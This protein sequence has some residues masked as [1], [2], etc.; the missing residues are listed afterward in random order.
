MEL[1]K[2]LRTC[3]IAH[4][5]HLADFGFKKITVNELIHNGYLDEIISEAGRFIILSEELRKFYATMKPDQLRLKHDAALTYIYLSKGPNEKATWVTDNGDRTDG[6]NGRPDATYYDKE[7]L[8]CVEITTPNYTTEQIMAKINYAN[9]INAK[10]EVY[11][12]W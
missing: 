6:F 8:V 2:T 7:T 12:I 10:L 5:G 9:T 11:K 3:K 1:I 4:I